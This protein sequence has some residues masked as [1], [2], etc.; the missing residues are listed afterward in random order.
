MRT[1]IFLSILCV[2]TLSAMAGSYYSDVVWTDKTNAYTDNQRFYKNWTSSGN[3]VEAPKFTLY[4][5]CNWTSTNDTITT[6][7]FTMYVGPAEGEGVFDITGLTLTATKATMAK[8][9]TI[10]GSTINVSDTLSLGP[11]QSYNPFYSLV[12]VSNSEINA[13]ELSILGPENNVVLT[14]TKTT[15]NMSGYDSSA[16]QK[17]ASLTVVG[18]SFTA[19]L[20]DEA[21]KFHV[22]ASTLTF[23]NTNVDM[24]GAIISTNNNGD[25]NTEINFDNTTF[26]G[27]IDLYSYD[28]QEYRSVVNIKNKSVVNVGAFNEDASDPVRGGIINV[29]GATLNLAAGMIQD[30]GSASTVYTTKMNLSNGATATIG[31][32][33]DI[34]ETTVSDAT[35]DAEAIFVDSGNIFSTTGNAVID[36]A[37]LSVTE[38]ANIS[39]ADTTTLN[40]SGL[41]VVLT[42][43][44]LQT[45]T[46]FNLNDIFGEETNLVLESVGENLTM[47]DLLGNSFEATISEGGILVAG[48]AIPEPSTYALLFGVAGLG[49]AACRRKRL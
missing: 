26:S 3:D 14:D 9:G 19:N 11:Q 20:I 8:S 36:A 47:S 48:A 33:L 35:L 18:G 38:G 32:T 39:I 22:N 41:E 1:Q 46:E 13:G 34:A 12:S 44:S 31:G 4:G 30:E 16:L 10:K 49:L 25:R 7:T 5:D 40:L 24:A 42:S 15:L 21:C 29:D 45:G 37:M 23:Q 6:T 28:S 2:S 43:S 27:I 17:G